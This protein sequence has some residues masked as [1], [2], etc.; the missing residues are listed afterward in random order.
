MSPAPPVA[1]PIP[2]SR[3]LEREV[4]VWLVGI[5]GA[6]L[7][8]A[9]GIDSA[10]YRRLALSNA[11]RSLEVLGGSIENALRLDMAEGRSSEVQQVLEELGR[12]ERI[13]ALRIVDPAGRVLRSSRPAE[14]GLSLG[15]DLAL[16]SGPRVSSAGPGR[17]RLSRPIANEPTCHR[18]HGAAS[19]LNGVLLLDYSLEEE[20]AR[21]RR[22]GILMAALLASSMTAAGVA[23]VRLLR[24]RV[25][26][27]LRR[28][29]EAMAKADRGD[30]PMAVEVTSSS[31]I[32]A[33]QRELNGMIR[34]IETQQRDLAQKERELAVQEAL[35]AKN[36][37]LEDANRE[38]NE[39]NRYYLEML[40]FISHEMKAPLSVI[41]GYSGLLL[42]GA[43]L[44]TPGAATQEALEALGRSSEALE[45]MLANYLDLARLE[46]GELSPE[47][48]RVDLVAD[49]LE[50]LLEELRPA[51]RMSGRSLTLSAR[52]GP[53][54][55]LADASLLR[56]AFGNAVVNALKYGKPRSQV[57]VEVQREG[58]DARVGIFNEGRGIPKAELER[59]FER[60]TRLD[61]EVTR[62]EKGSGLG[63]WIVRE[64]AR[65]HGGEA[66]A[67]SEE[68]QWAR[69]V[70][71]LPGANKVASG[72]GGS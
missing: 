62:A 1:P 9:L 64:I 3:K 71:R 70:L 47:L 27:P 24:A 25:A 10:I 36:R 22:H 39:K 23:L 53:V 45:A 8:I 40:G 72:E 54:P 12:S 50:P 41:K 34:R 68:G 15:E 35:A 55:A 7:A 4:I 67:E 42:S 26:R 19:E 58:G 60:F 30:L 2:T 28:M 17:L 21:V 20:N 44:G 18:C 48:R 33:L 16:R 13:D 65:R 14:L 63:L 66:W 38:V 52:E 32:G 56:S 61:N 11:T 51:A 59:I 69:I 46:R 49:V 31:E 29:Q 37:A 57:L 5:L 43:L 6:F